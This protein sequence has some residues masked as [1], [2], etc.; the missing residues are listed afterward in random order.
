MTTPVRPAAM[1]WGQH[2]ARTWAMDLDARGDE[3]I[4]VKRFDGSSGARWQI[5]SRI[6]GGHYKM[7]DA[8]ETLEAA[9]GAAVLLAMRLLP[10]RR[11]ALHAVLDAVPGVWWWKIA[12]GDDADAERRAVISQRTETTPE[13]AERSGRAAGAGW[14]LFVY[15]PG[16][17]RAF[18]QLPR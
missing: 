1:T 12:P 2:D 16:S 7:A 14:W 6:R 11:G 18:G 5:D 9:Q 15:G 13:A 17:A 10:T 4:E 8:F 3:W